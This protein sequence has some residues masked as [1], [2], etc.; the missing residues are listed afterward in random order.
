MVPRPLDRSGVD[1]QGDA[2]GEQNLTRT[3]GGVSQKQRGGCHIPL[4]HLS[5]SLFGVS[6]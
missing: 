1:A 5:L 3:Q 2:G 4:F 6:S